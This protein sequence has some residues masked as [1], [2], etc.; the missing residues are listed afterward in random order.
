[1]RGKVVSS[2]KVV[3]ALIAALLIGLPVATWLDV[4]ALT[5]ANLRRQADRT[6]GAASERRRAIAFDIQMEQI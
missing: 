2:T 4:N 6:N 3:A 5:E 1:M